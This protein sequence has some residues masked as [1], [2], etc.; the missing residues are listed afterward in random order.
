MMK[1]AIVDDEKIILDLVREKVSKILKQYKVDFDICE[2]TDGKSLM[3][4]YSK[5]PFD[6]IFLD[7]DM[8]DFTGIDVAKKLRSHDSST[9][10]IFVTNKDEMVYETIKYVPFRFIR[11]SKFDTEIYEALENYFRKKAKNKQVVI[12]STENGKKPLS[13]QDIVYVEVRS[14]KLTVHTNSGILEANGNLK[15]IELRIA[16]YGFIRIHQ[17]YLV[18]YRFI[19]VIKQKCVVLDNEDVLPLGRGRYENVKLTMMRFSR[20]M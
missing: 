18:N 4:S 20:E 2:F 16:E 12:F 19:D 8:P 3:K 10:I 11:K 15:D 7:I 9:E 14:H 6:L 17:S 1:I 5:Q 13:V